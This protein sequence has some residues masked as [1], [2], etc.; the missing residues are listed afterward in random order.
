[1]SSQPEMLINQAKAAYD[2]AKQMRRMIQDRERADNLNIENAIE[3]AEQAEKFG[4]DAKGAYWRDR[5]GLIEKERDS[6]IRDLESR[7]ESKERDG[8]KYEEEARDLAEKESDNNKKNLIM[9]ALHGLS[10]D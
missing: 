4:D 8:R 7:A 10:R 2:E 3:S 6:A 9:A 1:M 5:V